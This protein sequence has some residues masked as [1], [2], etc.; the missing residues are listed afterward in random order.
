QVRAEGTIY[1]DAFVTPANGP[2]TPR[3][4]SLATSTALVTSPHRA[5]G[6]DAA[7]VT[8]TV[9]DASGNPLAGKPVWVAL[10]A[11]GVEL[12]QAPVTSGADGTASFTMTSTE[13][14]AFAPTILIV[15]GPV[16]L[17]L[18]QPVV[19]FTAGTITGR[20][21]EDLDR[22]GTQD[23][24]E[25]GVVGVPVALN[26]DQGAQQG[27]TA[28]GSDGSF[29]FSSLG[30]GSYQLVASALAD[31]AFS[32]PAQLSVNL[33]A[34]GTS[35]G[36]GFGAYA[37]AQ[38]D[39]VVWND[40]NQNGT[41]DTGETGIAGVTVAANGSAGPAASAT[42]DAQGRYKLAVP[43]PK[44]AAP[45]NYTFNAQPSKVTE[46]AIS[47]IEN[48]QFAHGTYDIDPFTTTDNVT[49]D[50]PSFDLDPST[51]PQN[52]NFETGDLSGWTASSGITI[53]SGGMDGSRYA[54]TPNL[55]NG[56]L[57]S[58][59]F[60]IGTEA[61]TLFWQWRTRWGSESYVQLL[62]ESGQQVLRTVVNNGGTNG[63]WQKA[64]ADVSTYRGQKVRLRFVSSGY[65][66]SGGNW[67]HID[68]VGLE[69]SVP[70][71]EMI[72]NTWGSNGALY[73]ISSNDGVDGAY[74]FTSSPNLGLTSAVFEVGAE[75]QTLSWQWRTRWGSE[76]YVQLL[77]ESGQQVL[78]TVVNNGGTNGSW[79]K[80][81]AD[82]STYRGQKV[83]L[84]FVSSGYGGSGGNWFHID[85]VGLEV[86]V[87]GWEMIGNTW[88]SNGALY[89]ISSN[90]GVDGAYAFTSSPNLGLTSAPFEIGA[91]AQTL[92]WQWRTRWGSETYVQLLDESG[93]QVL[94][95]VVNNGGTNG[96]WQQ[97]FADVSTYH[98]QK[99]R[100]RF[101]SSGYGG[102][103]GNW[104]HI[105]NVGLE[106]SVPGWQAS[107]NT[108]GSNG[109]LYGIS[110]ATDGI[111][112]PYAFMSGPSFALTS[113]AFEIGAEAQT[114]NWQWRTRWGSET[115]MQLL[116][117]S[118]QQVLR[119]LVNNGG[120][121]GVWHDATND[122]R[123]L[124]G[125]KV[126]LRIS[127]SGYGGSGGNW[128]HL[129]NVRLEPAAKETYT[130][131]QTNLAGWTSSTPDTVSVQ[132]RGGS[133]VVVNFGDYGGVSAAPAT[134]K[135]AAAL[136]TPAQVQATISQAD[137]SLWS[138]LGAAAQAD[139]QLEVA[140]LD[141]L[142]ATNP[143]TPTASVTDTTTL[144]KMSNYLLQ[145]QQADGAWYSEHNGPE[146]WW[147]NTSGTNRSPALTAYTIVALAKV[148]DLTGDAKYRTALVK[149][150]SA[151]LPWP[152][153]GRNTD[154]M[155]AII[156]LHAALPYIED[157]AL[158]TRMEDRMLLLATYLRGQQHADGGWDI[159][160]NTTI[161]DPLPTAG[162]LYA[163]SR[164]QPV[165]TDTALMRATEYL[166]KNQ[167]VDG[168]WT[169]RYHSNPI[170]PTTWVDMSLPWIYEVLSS[171]SLNVAHVVPQ[172][173]VEVLADSFSPTPTTTPGDAATTYGWQY[174]QTERERVRE[175]S[176]RSRLTNMRP[177]EV[178]QVSNGTTVTYSIESGSNTITLPPLFVQ[179]PHIITIDPTTRVTSP[180][181][182]AIYQVEVYNPT[183][184]PQIYALAVSGLPG[185]WTELTSMVTLSPGARQKVPLTIHPSAT[186][187]AATT[188][189][190]VTATTTSGGQDAVQADLTIVETPK[191]TITPAFAEAEIGQAVSYTLT[192]TNGEAE[193]RTYAL[194]ATGLGSNTHNLP[195]TIAVGPNASV[196]QQFTVTARAARGLYPFTVTA[197][198][199]RNG[200]TLS[201]RDEAT[202]AVLSQPKV[203]ATLQPPTATGGPGVPVLYR[204]NVTNAGDILDTYSFDINLPDGWSAQL[205]AND[206]PVSTLELTPFVFNTAELWLLVTP[207]TTATPGEY[208][209]D[210]VVQSQLNPQVR[211]VVNG[212]L[213]VSQ[214]GVRVEITPE[215]TTLSP[216]GSG[217]WQVAVTNTGTRADTYQLSA[218][219]IVS[220]TAQFAPAAVSLAPGQT[221][222]VQLTANNLTYALAQTYGF[223]VTARSTANPAIHNS[224][225]AEITFSGYEA[226]TAA[227]QPASQTL[228]DSLETSYLLL[229]TNTGNL[230]T[231]YRLDPSAAPSGLALD[232]ATEELYVPAHMTAG[233]LLNVKATKAGTFQLTVAVTS[234]SGAASA[235][236]QGVLIIDG[237]AVPTPVPT[238]TP[239]LT[240]SPTETPTP[241]NTPTSTPTF[242]PTPTE[243]PTP[244]ATNTAT[245]TPTQTSTPTATATQTPT[246]TST[247][248]ATA[249]P[250]NTPTGTVP[251]TN[252]PTQT[253]TPTNTPTLTPTPANGAPTVSANGPYTVA[254]GGLVTIAATGS[255]PEGQTLT[256][257][258]DL[259][260]DGTYETTGNPIT[261]SA[262]QIDGPSTV[263]IRVRTTD[264]GGLSATATTTLTVTNVAPTV[265]TLT[266]PQDPA[267][268]NTFVSG[269]ATF[270]DPGIADTHTARWD[271]GDGSSSNGV[272]SESNG[273]G[274]VSGTHGYTQPGVYTVRLTV[275]DDDGGSGELLFRYV[276]VFDPTG[277][278][279]TGGG[280]INSPVG[281]CKLT[282][283]CEG[284]TGRA[285]FGFNSKYQKN[286]TVPTGQTEFQFKAGNFN[287]HSSVYEWLVVAGAKA[288]YKGSGTINGSG[289]YGFMLTA[290][291]GQIN[292]GGG[293]DKFRIKIWNKTSGAVVYDNQ[294]GAG[295]DAEPTTTLQGGSIVIHR[296]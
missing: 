23:A 47:R 84:R 72:G 158:A 196:T 157:D 218:S 50:R 96:S 205:M 254:E 145:Q 236:A 41:R 283:V 258:W 276:V 265:T 82:V 3:H 143:V 234:T 281:A 22:D 263:T 100:L 184:S 29:T 112:G 232:L 235:S 238:S 220:A 46:P 164:L 271:W 229:V 198:I 69:V 186:A 147:A 118:G 230:D 94:R 162:M 56:S 137:L 65:G 201:A 26:D 226:V 174:N 134:N 63:S 67:F 39:G 36:H 172:P 243:T 1:V 76:S 45:A 109:A 209:F 70:G 71:W 142:G 169:S 244:T 61:Q 293:V 9:R 18:P 78:R 5:D 248:T 213:V 214:Y 246:Q 190:V 219:G 284:A 15:D 75:V 27:S 138:Q 268:I 32:T 239:T 269:S 242:T 245:Q 10:A 105:D 34:F 223:G 74:A 97:A 167:R 151:M 135:L 170:M 53:A 130:I 99:V 286:A 136:A 194:A 227:L 273:S 148:Y 17:T 294:L 149:A 24:G 289:D 14:G 132:A 154:A 270:T 31:W 274:T 187:T 28:T 152:Y 104:F 255:D 200:G 241:T 129:D 115:Y 19:Q 179:A 216:N 272:V 133:R 8:V 296:N 171:Y 124:R 207:A 116:D 155:H 261:A 121:N 228:T 176:F 13:A 6:T 131:T 60:Q 12:S 278:Y 91:D 292:G 107:G 119:T 215:R 88:G 33:D 168:Q 222:V 139:R 38:V 103:G 159:Y 83:R 282:S 185:E 193:A 237:G 210:V 93:Q 66:G 80:A 113:T 275:T 249:T 120:T 233:V 62:D 79:Q 204:L 122:V 86:S 40:A 37:V 140:A 163:L 203:A 73:G 231:T 166:L 287:F 267:Q 182:E 197:S 295:D 77:D 165:S 277:G 250:T 114:L 126:R 146:Y 92:F 25:P 262:A 108:W 106:V 202:L 208:D 251:P 206:V 199:N 178:R 42:T 49:F 21:F 189:F 54:A 247:P 30:A 68:N 44:P 55:P 11:A 57:T 59:V 188:T 87:P 16:T 141:V 125:Q 43:A 101:V 20:V 288:Q 51:Y 127:S 290:I 224:D 191:L 153:T 48:S 212:V 280:F 156:G 81:F 180:G 285:N 259:N 211:A 181:G 111:D 260:G 173:G 192:L 279:V 117:E 102:S 161:S 217:T 225:T 89:G 195:A 128:F 177:G 85:N 64:F 240:P 266:L 183:A 58:S 150:S 98:G 144:I 221:Q 35:G 90:D 52:Y 291:D 160:P 253:P 264:S 4:V 256:F 257:A 123:T 252:T 7:T 95:T 110:T 2:Q 175:L